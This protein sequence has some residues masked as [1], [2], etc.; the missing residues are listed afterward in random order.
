MAI[1]PADIGCSSLTPRAIVPE[2]F[3][4]TPAGGDSFHL[5]RQIIDRVKAVIWDRTE[6]QMRYQCLARETQAASPGA[7]LSQRVE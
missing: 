2:A 5:Q 3:D 4:A 6:L 7:V 1:A